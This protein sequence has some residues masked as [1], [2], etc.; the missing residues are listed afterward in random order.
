MRDKPFG[1][2]RLLDLIA[3]YGAS[4]TAWPEAERVSAES[5]LQLATQEVQDRLSEAR[6][7]DRLIGS[8]KPPEPDPALFDRICA[9][10]PR[11]LSDDAEGPSVPMGLRV[12]LNI[13]AVVAALG[14]GLISGYAAASE[15]A[16]EFVVPDRLGEQGS[17]YLEQDLP[18]WMI[19]DEERL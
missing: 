7:L 11:A 13:G 4:P 1:E 9:A 5:C 3:A 16:T 15:K 19:G 18:V 6:L 14:I 10:V 2:D 8:L 17:W 12:R